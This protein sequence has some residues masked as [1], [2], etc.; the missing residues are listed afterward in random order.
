[1]LFLFE[2]M[3]VLHTK[4]KFHTERHK[5]ERQNNTHH[6]DYMFFTC[7]HRLK[8]IRESAVEKKKRSKKLKFMKNIIR[9]SLHLKMGNIFKKTD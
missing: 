9:N 5:T 1:M 3:F 6:N 4:R 7:V 2:I 8:K